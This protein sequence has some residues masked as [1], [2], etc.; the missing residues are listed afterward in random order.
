[1]SAPGEFFV[2]LFFTRIELREGEGEGEG[3]G[4]REGDGPVAHRQEIVAAQIGVIPEQGGKLRQQ[5]EGEIFGRGAG[6]EQREHVGDE[7][8][9]L[10]H[11][12]EEIGD[13][14]GEHKRAAEDGPHRG[15]A[16]PE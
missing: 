2:R 12:R 6:E 11:V 8:I 16:A 7:E 5:R 14:D 3:Q 13:A 15:P 4:D 9:A 10:V 1:M